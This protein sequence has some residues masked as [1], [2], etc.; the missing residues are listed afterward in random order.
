[1]RINNN[2]GLMFWLSAFN[3]LLKVE[4]FQQV[5]R[6]CTNLFVYSAFGIPFQIEQMICFS[7]L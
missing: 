5:D 6:Q 1:M 3:N 2:I 7:V 4:P